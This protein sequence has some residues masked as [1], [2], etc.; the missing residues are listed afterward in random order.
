MLGELIEA[1]TKVEG[2]E[3]NL[4]K[5]AELEKQLLGDIQPFKAEVAE[6]KKEA[7]DG[8]EEGETQTAIEDAEKP[9]DEGEGPGPQL[10]QDQRLGYLKQKCDDLTEELKKV[11]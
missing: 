1:L 4:D 9:A 3:A 6:A 8:N 5:I 11:Q 2:H 7:E 10:N